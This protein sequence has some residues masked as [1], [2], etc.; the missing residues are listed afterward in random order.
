VVQQIQDGE[1][2][3]VWPRELSEKSVWTLPRYGDKSA[4]AD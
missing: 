2:V 3:T 4:A 1:L